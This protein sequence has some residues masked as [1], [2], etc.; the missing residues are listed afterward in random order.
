MILFQF[1][2]MF[3]TVQKKWQETF[4]YIGLKDT[5]TLVYDKA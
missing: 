4:V 1:L 2:P 3:G 5:R